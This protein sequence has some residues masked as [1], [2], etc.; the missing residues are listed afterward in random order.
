MP[1][2]IQPYQTGGGI[3]RTAAGFDAAAAALSFFGQRQAAMRQAE[4]QAHATAAAVAHLGPWFS[5]LDAATQAKLL[6]ELAKN[7]PELFASVAQGMQPIAPDPLKQARDAAQL[8]DITSQM[9][10][11]PAAAAIA[12]SRRNAATYGD[13]FAASGP[14]VEQTNL[15]ALPADVQ[16]KALRVHAKVEPS[17]D[18]VAKEAGDTQRNAATTATSRYVAD[19]NAAT[20][21]QRIAAGSAQ[22]AADTSGLSDYSKKAIAEIDP[23]LAQV[24]KVIDGYAPYKAQN[25]MLTDRDLA[26]YG[27]YR[28]G[29]AL[30]DTDP[31]SL[32]APL[33]MLDVSA[34]ARILKGGSRSMQ[35][36]KLA[37]QHTPNPTSTRA[38]IYQ[39]AVQMYAYLKDAR[40]AAIAEGGDVS[41]EDAR[42]NIPRPTTFGG[43]TATGSTPTAGPQYKMTA[44]GANGQKIGS[45]DGVSWFDLGTGQKVQ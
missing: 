10:T 20:Q 23:L 44:T 4:A 15:A 12:M 9:P 39:R 34:A 29:G 18:V 42:N 14:I 3:S 41:A 8:G 16:P 31:M 26:S 6:P 17:A 30:E 38:S 13:T 45:N 11:D 25:N 28:A 2:L 33:A 36:L 35:A 21:R 1:R 19:T 24:S 37:K 22:T 5:S 40:D 7:S 27:K 43:P 32:A